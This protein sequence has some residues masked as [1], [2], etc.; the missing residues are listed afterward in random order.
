MINRLENALINR[1]ANDAEAIEIVGGD[2]SVVQMPPALAQL[3]LDATQGFA[4]RFGEGTQVQVVIDA[5]VTS[6]SQFQARIEICLAGNGLPALMATPHTSV[7]LD[8]VRSKAIVGSR[9]LQMAPRDIAVLAW[10]LQ[11]T[12]AGDACALRDRLQSEAAPR[13]RSRADLKIIEMGA[14]RCTRRAYRRVAFFRSAASLRRLNEGFP[15]HWFYEFNAEIDQLADRLLTKDIGQALARIRRQLEGEFGKQ[16]ASRIISFDRES[17]A[18]PL[19]ADDISIIIH[20]D[21]AD[22]PELPEGVICAAEEL[23]RHLSSPGSDRQT[24]I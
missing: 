11:A 19:S 6:G 5:M 3:L 16:M 23:Q 22:H 20:A 17:F 15:L 13:H 18:S 9:S 2:T 14:D 24:Q 12:Q 4:E 10:I 1:V 8:L 21:L 7:V